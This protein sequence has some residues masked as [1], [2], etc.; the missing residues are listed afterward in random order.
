MSVIIAIARPNN[1]PVEIFLCDNNRFYCCET[2]VVGKAQI[3]FGYVFRPSA[4]A[5][6]NRVF[7]AIHRQRAKIQA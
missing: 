4:G 1:A 3:D 6:K 7:Y 5:L 2:A